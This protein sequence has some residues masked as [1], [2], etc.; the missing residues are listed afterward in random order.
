[1]EA[2]WLL[3]RIFLLR[4]FSFQLEFRDVILSSIRVSFPFSWALLSASSAGVD[5]VQGLICPTAI[6]LLNMTE[7][8]RKYTFVR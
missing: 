5:P 4:N 2:S 8:M 3:G 6:Q 7:Y 1:M